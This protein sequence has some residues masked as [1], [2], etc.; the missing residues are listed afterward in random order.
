[1]KT[2]YNPSTKTTYI[3]NKK[4]QIVKS[5]QPNR[6][7]KCRECGDGNSIGQAGKYKGLCQICRRKQ[8]YK[9]NKEIENL[10]CREN[11]W[12]NNGKIKMLERRYG[13]NYIKTMKRDGFKCTKCGTT[14][15][16]QVHHIDKTGMKTVGSY[17]YSNN[18]LSNLLTLCHSCHLKLH[19]PKV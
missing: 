17:K 14:K 13:G 8:Y 4:G 7:T 18:N 15:R 6:I 11:Y 19:N 5:Y 3:L 9:D 12:K 16:L 1:M 2:I 10:K